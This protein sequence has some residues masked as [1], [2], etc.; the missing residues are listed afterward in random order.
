MSVYFYRIL[1]VYIFVVGFVTTWWRHA[2]DGP[3]WTPLVEAECS[4]CRDKW[5]SQFLFLNNFY[6][7]DEK[8][9]IQT[10]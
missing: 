8:C 6:K 2:S 10:W 3:L 5:W 4:R 9:L 1:P 7:P